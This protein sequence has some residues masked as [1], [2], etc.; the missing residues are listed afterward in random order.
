M[1]MDNKGRREN[2]VGTSLQF[3]MSSYKPS[4][5]ICTRIAWS[6]TVMYL[7]QANQNM[8]QLICSVGKVSQSKYI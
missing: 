2:K 6:T 4:Y 8:V 3:E 5:Y 7:G 1:Y